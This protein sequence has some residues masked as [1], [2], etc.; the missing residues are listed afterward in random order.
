MSFYQAALN[1]RKIK[2]LQTHQRFTAILQFIVVVFLKWFQR[3]MSF[4]YW[5][6]T[7]TT[8]RHNKKEEID[9]QLHETQQ[10]FCFFFFFSVSRCVKWRRKDFQSFSHCAMLFFF[11]FPVFVLF[12][13]LYIYLFSFVVGICVRRGFFTLS[14]TSN[15]YLHQLLQTE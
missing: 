15:V 3:E 8:H 11:Q 13:E 6:C 10:T 7:T 9:S 5:K 1:R 4:E 14:N 12:R 2:R